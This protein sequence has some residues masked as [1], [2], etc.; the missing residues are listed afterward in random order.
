MQMLKIKN[1]WFTFDLLKNII[2]QKKVS[3]QKVL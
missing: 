1:N 3:W 2:E